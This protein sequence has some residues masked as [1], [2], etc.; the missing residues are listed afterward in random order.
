MIV[1][2]NKHSLRKD[3]FGIIHDLGKKLRYANANTF[4]DAS[5]KCRAYIK[6]RNMGASCFTGGAIY[7]DKKNHIA[8]VAYNG[9]VFDLNHKLLYNPYDEE[10]N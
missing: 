9:K 7:D 4:K 6:I 10:D 2:L 5:E 8:D 3:H 1:L